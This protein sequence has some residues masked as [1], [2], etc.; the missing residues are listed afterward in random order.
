[1]RYSAS[2]RGFF[3]EDLDYSSVPEDCVEITEADY[4]LLMDGQA[5]GHEIVPDVSRIGYPKLVVAV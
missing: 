4:L 5:A 3:S 1:M 2:A